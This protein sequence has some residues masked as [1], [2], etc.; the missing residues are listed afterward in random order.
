MAG[1]GFLNVFLAD[2]WFRRALAQVREAGERFGAG[3]LPAELRERVLVEFVSANPTG[4]ITV[5]SGRHAAY[6]DAL[7]RV[8]DF[9]GHDVER[10][11][12]VNDYGTQ[13]DLFAASIAARMRGEEPPE[14]GYKGEYV[15]EL[16]AELAA[17]GLGPDDLE[18]ARPAR[19]RAD[20]RSGA[21]RR[22]SASASASIASS[23][24]A[25]STT[26][27]A[28]RRR[29]RRSAP[30]TCTSTRVPCGCAPPRSATTRIGC[31]A[32]PPAS[33]P[34]SR[35]TSPTTRTSAARGYDRLI[36]VLGADHHGYVARM[37]AAFACSGRARPD[38]ARDHAARATSWSGASA[39]RCRSARASS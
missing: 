37:K 38:R 4:P 19:G 33:R 20:D 7:A 23:S 3:A 39:L 18:R 8:L 13:I 17:E 36:N 21:G 27:G 34:T 35:P 25:R 26:R 24:S 1:P 29:S 5:A 22:S 30:S 14:D 15:A 32:A 10:E 11:F 6:G 2:S 16:A 28:C 12:Y 31:F 9:A